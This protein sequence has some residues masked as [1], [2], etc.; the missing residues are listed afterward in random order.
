[1]AVFFILLGFSYASAEINPTPAALPRFA[2]LGDSMTW[3]GG[4]SCQNPTGWSYILQQ[5]GIADK[6]DMYA[7]SGATW[8]NT[9]STQRNPSFYSEILHDDNVVY[10]QA[11]RLIEKAD[12][13][14]EIP[15]III[16][17]AGANDA[18]FASKRPGIYNQDESTEKYTIASD[19]ASVT[20]LEGSISLVSDILQ[21]RFPKATLLFITPLQ[22]SKT[23]AET[24]FK[25]SEIIAETAT[26][27]GYPV[28][29]PD[30]ETAINHDQ[31]SKSP[32][33]TYD[34]VHTNPKGALLLGNYILNSLSTLSLKTENINR[35]T[36][37]E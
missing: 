12:S 5:S 15:D 28:L 18:W 37:N 13:C 35:K 27:K 24:I 8:T 11:I 14:Q 21:E 16:L 10:N 36:Q 6:I 1:M 17:F 34:G 20:T 31:E 25:V 4:D 7:R 3:I 22:M 32:T 23:D 29:R 19:P 9:T 2:L 26:Q 33:Y 30:K